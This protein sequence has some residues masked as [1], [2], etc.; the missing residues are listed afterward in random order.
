MTRT[1]QDDS[2]E[3]KQIE[4][5][6]LKE[7]QGRSNKYIPDASVNID[8][9]EYFVELKSYDAERQQVSTAR[10]V[11]MHKI[12]LWREVMWVISE[13][14]KTE[15]GFEF[16]GEHH[17]CFPEDLDPWFKRQEEKLLHGTKTYG[18][19]ND[20]YAVRQAG[21]TFGLSQEL[22]ERVENVLTKRGGLNDPKISAPK[23]KMA[24]HKLNNN[25]L[26]HSLRHLIKNRRTNNGQ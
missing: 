18:G 21:T 11:T 24:G 14:K 13:Y 17:L 22:L 23:F 16:T 9:V 15:G 4:L 5:F 8:G 12:S 2:R 7:L 20:W 25:N 6:M 10:N 1:T 26:A 3:K 19:L